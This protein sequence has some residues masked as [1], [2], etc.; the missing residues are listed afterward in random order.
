MPAGRGTKPRI[1][2]LVVDDSLFMRTVISRMLEDAGD[3]DVVE[4]VSS[5]E[6]VPDAVRRHKPD[7]V[8]LDIVMPGIDGLMVL[9]QLMET[10][11]LP[12]LM[13]STLTTENADATIRALEM[14]AVDVVA[15]PSDM[16]LM[17]PKIA[18]DLAEKVRVAA[19]VDS[20]HL[21][22]QP[23]WS[24]APIA[25]HKPSSYAAPLEALVVGSSTGGLPALNAVASALDADFPAGVLLIQLM[26]P[27]FTTAFAERLA[28]TCQLPVRE[29]RDGDLFEPGRILVAPSGKNVSFVRSANL[30]Q[31]VVSDVPDDGERISAIDHAMTS[32][33]QIFAERGMGVILTGMG[34]DG[35][36]GL[37]AMRRA[38]AY[39][40]AEHEDSA[41]IWGMPRAAAQAGAV[42]SLAHVHEIPVLVA[43]RAQRGR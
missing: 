42:V 20:S 37:R 22:A 6:E 29:A 36:M 32:A 38:G 1:R 40:V 12:V 11:P 23:E 18:S 9:K 15:K 7:V 17:M 39:T 27:G 13:L 41:V 24:E 33:A 16:P 8:T 4:A 43:A 14:G 26:P 31:L 3:I 5:G 25:T 19:G 34:D 30:V 21:G 10:S 28:Q 35:A 2:V